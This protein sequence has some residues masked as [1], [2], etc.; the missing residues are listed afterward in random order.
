MTNETK[1]FAFIELQNP[2]GVTNAEIVKATGISPHQQVFQITQ[3]LR[4]A[5]KIVGIRSGNEWV[6]NL[7]Q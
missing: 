1:V 7:K 4:R 5:R 6:F 2:R 3:R